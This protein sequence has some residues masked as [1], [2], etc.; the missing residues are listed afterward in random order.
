MHPVLFHIGPFTLY[1]YGLMLALGAGLGLWLLSFL[2]ARS[3]LDRDRVG[4]LA[5]WVLV[6]ALAGSR[7]LFVILEPAGFIAQPWRVFFIWEGGLVFYGGVIA[8]LAAGVILARR[9]KL[10]L[11]PLLDC[12]GPAL[13]LGQALG[14][15]GCFLAGCCYGLP[16]E[17]GLCAVTFT[18]PASLASPHGVPLHP[19]QLYSSGA[20]FLI[21]VF[22]LWLWPRRRFAGQIFFSYGL[23]HGIART[24]IEQ[25]RADYRGEPILGP[26]TPTAV[27]G[28]GFALFS[29]IM[30]VVLSRRQKPP[31]QSPGH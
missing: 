4:S 15:I 6:S 17:H 19:T 7:L 31:T 25:F 5:I 18:D 8:G 10:A 3:G 24:I 28:L 29:L 11:L 26:L 23:L 27:F 22:L 14:R 12:F 13:A 30:L 20:L 9:W 16:W 21:M 1:S 2:A